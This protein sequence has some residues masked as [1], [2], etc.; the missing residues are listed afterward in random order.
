MLVCSIMNDRTAGANLATVYIPG[1]GRAALQNSTNDIIAY[2]NP[3]TVTALVP[4]MTSA[5]GGG[6][7]TVLGE[8]SSRE[9]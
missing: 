8:S 3:L 1:K 7:V 5:L 9:V 6:L 2:V 4:Y